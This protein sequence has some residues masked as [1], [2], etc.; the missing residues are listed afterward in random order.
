MKDDRSVLI[1]SSYIRINI[2]SLIRISKEEAY[3][4]IQHKINISKIQQNYQKVLWEE[5]I[6]F[7]ASLIIRMYM[8]I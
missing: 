2:K 1:S 3:E 4:K 7:Y 5:I 6:R 8:K